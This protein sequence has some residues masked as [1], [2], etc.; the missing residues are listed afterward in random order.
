ME[1]HRLKAFCLLAEMKSFSKA[2]EA[3]FITQSAMSHLI[4][5]LEDELGIK[6]INRHSKTISLTPAGRVFYQHAKRILAL[7]REMENDIY[8]IA[9]KVKGVLYIGATPTAAIYLLPQVFYDFLKKYPEVRIE[10][11]VASTER[12]L[13]NLEKGTVDLGIIEG[14]IKNTNL[15]SEEIAEDEIVV[16]VSDD[17]PLTEKNSIVPGDLVTQPFIMPEKGSGL[18]EFIE[19]FFHDNSI[20]PEN[21]RISMIIDNPELIIQVVQS[22]MGIS[23]VSKWAVFKALK[24]GSIKVLPIKNTKLMRKFYTVSVEDEPTALTVK[25]FRDFIR[26]YRF[27]IPF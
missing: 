15:S 14:N 18:R 17:N 20:N 12:V 9:N 22:G 11:S 23:F 7:Y 27:F 13:E 21:I 8:C 2:A 6:L 3:K 16:I 10:L 1:D 24:D 4:K 26:E 5:N 19:D 25:T